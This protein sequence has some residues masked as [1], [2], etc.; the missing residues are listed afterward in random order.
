MEDKMSMLKHL[1]DDLQKRKLEILE[2]IKITS[3]CPLRFSPSLFGYNTLLD[4]I[5]AGT[6]IVL[7]TYIFIFL[8][9]LLF[10]LFLQPILG[11]FMPRILSD[12]L[13]FIC[14]FVIPFPV[15]LLYYINHYKKCYYKILNDWRERN[16]EKLSSLH[17]N[18]DEITNKITHV[19]YLINTN[20]SE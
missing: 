15:M 3:T 12:I 9:M 4:Y 18:L 17:K 19:N 11:Y 20:C 16:R 2:Q 10:G 1:N 13:G 5:D 7:D 8:L 6:E 14:V